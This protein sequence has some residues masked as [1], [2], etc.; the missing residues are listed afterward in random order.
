M[1]IN[2]QHDE[3][4]KYSK[5]WKEMDDAM[6]EQDTIHAKGEAYLPKT[7][8]MKDDTTGRYERYKQR[9]RFPGIVRKSLTGIVGLMFEKDP[10]G[11]SEDPITKT[12]QGNIHLGRDVARDVA[13]YGRSIL[14]VDAPK[15]DEQGNG[16][17]PF[18][19]RYHPQSLINWKIDPD[20]PSK[21]T[22]AVFE[23][24]HSVE[25]PDD[26]YAHKT[27]KRYRRY[28]VLDGS[29]HLAVLND[30]NDIVEEERDLKIGSL[31][32]FAIGSISVDPPCDPVPLL[33]VKDCAVA[34]YQI[35]ADLRQDLYQ[36]GQKQAWMS[37]ITQEQYD[38]N[39]KAGYGAGSTWFLGQEGQ[40][41]LLESSGSSY[42]DA[43]N[44][45]DYEFKEA[46]K[47]AVD[48]TQRSDSSES[49]RALQI[50]AAAQHASIYTM[51]DS[52]SI[53]IT[54]AISFMAAW[55][56]NS[57]PEPFR[58]RTEFSNEEAVDQI[59]NALNSAVN[60][61]NAPQ[62]AVFNAVRRAGYSD[63]SDED[64][65]KEIDSQDGLLP[66]EGG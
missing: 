34:I 27:E 62:S 42:D 16:G 47:Y 54:Q 50:R 52:I 40:A 46:A 35:S 63:L 38:A 59:I 39:I 64:M 9:A 65:R 56:G 10:E 58:I 44:E 21:F 29:V 3:Y 15:P 28:R 2:T 48:L 8:G 53:G 11:A 1:P 43:A 41:G 51:A 37:G 12:G 36:T 5:R 25:D 57:E 17:N 49:G 33:P 32:V 66:G 18:I 24:E 14:V 7:S 60:S 26:I 20:N 61:R 22:M 31:G 4:K 13:A 6:D 45:R 19:V 30:K 23:E 55:G